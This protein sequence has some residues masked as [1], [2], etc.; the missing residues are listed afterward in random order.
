MAK[1]RRGCA[2]IAFLLLLIGGAVGGWFGWKWYQKRLPPPPSGAELRVHILDVGQ[3][4]AILILGPEDANTKQRKTILIDAGDTGRGKGILETLRKNGVAQLDWLILTHPH[5]DHIGA[6]DEIIKGVKVLQVIDTD[7]AP[8]GPDIP[9]PPAPA[10]GKKGKPAPPPAKPS[11]IP[12]LPTVKAFN[13]YRAALNETKTPR[14][15]AEAG[16]KIDLGGNAFLTII[17]PVG[18][19]FREDQM[20]G[21]GN[22]LNANSLVMRL[23]YGAFSML[24]AGDAERVTEERLMQKETPLTANVLK[25]GHHGSKYATTERWLQAVKPAA[26][27]V[28]LGEYNRYGHPAQSVLDRLKAAKIQLYRTDLQGE[29]IITTN[30]KAPAKDKPAFEIKALKEAKT[31]IWAG[32]EAQKDDS[33]RS[34]FIAY[35]DFGPPPKEKNSTRRHG[36]TETQR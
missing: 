14:A 19:A 25:I 4:D 8:P 17:A 6:A 28:S 12:E 36:G 15:K 23:D 21:S 33:D 22:M 2:P 20:A 18:N 1:L 16:Q 5:V 13:E 34:G 9:A 24:L 27:I 11:K 26:A 32:R 29:I 7:T 3:G 10:P 35:G 31:D 30:G